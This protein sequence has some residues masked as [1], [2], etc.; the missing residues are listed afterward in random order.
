MA[1]HGN[2]KT[3]RGVPQVD[4]TSFGKP[5]GGSSVAK[6]SARRRVRSRRSQSAGASNAQTLIT[7]RNLLLG[8]AGIGAAAVG[9]V[10]VRALTSREESSNED[11]TTI[12]VPEDAVFDLEACAE[13]DAGDAF[14]LIGNFELPFGTLVWADDE[15]VA[16]CLFPT[17]EPSPLVYMGIL[18]LGNGSYYILRESA[19]GA[20]EGF[21]IYDVRASSEGLVWLEAAIMEGLWRIYVATLGGDLSLGEP[22]LVEEGMSDVEVPSITIVGEHAFWQTMAPISN[23]N[24]RREPSALKRASLKSGKA[25]TV[26]EAT[27][28]MSAP[29]VPYGESVVFTPRHEEATSYCDLVRIEAKSGKVQDQI[30]LPSGMMPHQVGF[31]PTGFAFC[32]ENIYDYGGGI[33]NLGTYTPAAAPKNGDYNS[34]PWF[35]FNR[36]PTAAPCWCTENWFMVKSNQSVCAVNLANKVFCSFGVESGCQDWGDFLVS[37]G[38]RS[39]VVTASQIDQ[40]DNEGKETKM[41][42]VRVW[43]PLANTPSNPGEN[44]SSSTQE[45]NQDQ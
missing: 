15:N 5:A 25:Q 38:M 9:A 42:Q 2:K 6:A 39:T 44:A 33:A 14:E 4:T 28:R 40:V 12:E 24:A 31:G 18:S 13:V 1:Q 43:Q 8:A 45:Q 29:P 32:F 23:E 11:I 3:K 7:R 41:T 16:A 26:Y 34:L 22:Q 20:E 35:R 19:V 30:T 21:E 27:G 17:E 37:S 10:G 36:T